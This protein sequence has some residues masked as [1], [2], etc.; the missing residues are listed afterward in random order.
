MAVAGAATE[1]RD[2]DL[3]LIAAADLSALKGTIVRVT[4]E[5]SVNVVTVAPQQPIGILINKPISGAAALVRVRGKC[6]AIAGAAIT[7]GARLMWG[8]GGKVITLSGTT[9][10]VVGVALQAAGA[11]G[12]VI[13]I[14]VTTGE[15]PAAA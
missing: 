4:A 12:D 6:K 3:S 8:T 14:L 2:D 11:D 15:Q 13:E 1:F 10:Y 9:N 7:V 5:Q